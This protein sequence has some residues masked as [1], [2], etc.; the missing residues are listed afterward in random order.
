[1]TDSTIANKDVR[2]LTPSEDLPASHG[3][4]TLYET[5]SVKLL[6]YFL[7]RVDDREDAADLVAETALIPWR[8]AADV[9]SE[10]ESARMW[11]YGIARRVLATHRRS[12]MRRSTLADRLRSE[13]ISTDTVSNPRIEDVRQAVLTLPRREEELI[14]LVHWEGFSVAQAAIIIGIRPGAARMRYHR[15]RQ[16]LLAALS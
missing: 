12:Q 1:V 9:P 6:G 13:L 14:A 4:S 2:A 10:P 3:V 8:R 7:R 11:M 16:R 5:E 15:A